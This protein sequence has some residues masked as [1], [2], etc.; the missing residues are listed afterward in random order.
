MT[1]LELGDM[2]GLIARGYGDLKAAC[3]LVLE[4]VDRG[5]ARTW[6]RTLAP[7]VTPARP[8]PD[9]E[10][11]HVAFTCE[12]LRQLG[13]DEQALE[14]FSR[15]FWEGMGEPHR[16]RHLLGDRD[17]SAPET[18]RWGGP[19]AHVLLLLFA[20]DPDLVELLCDR[21][22][23]AYVGLRELQRLDTYPFDPPREHFGFSDGIAQPIVEGLSRTGSPGNTIAPGEFI[24][25]YRNQYGKLPLS[26]VVAAD[27]DP[28][29]ILRRV[30]TEDGSEAGDLGRNGS[31][32]VFRQR[33]QD[34]R[35]FWRFVDKAARL[36]DGTSDREGRVR[37]AAKMVG[38]WPSGAP[39]TLCPDR[40]DTSQ[41]RRDDFGYL[42]RDAHGHFCPMGA[43]IRRTNPRD[44]LEGS[45]EESLMISNRHR[46]LRRGRPYG[47]PIS[48]TLDVDEILRAEE[49]EGEVGLHFICLNADIARQFE[50]VQHT[51]MNN[52]KFAGLYTDADP[53]MGHQE[54]SQGTFTLQGAPVRMRVN[55]MERFVEVRGGG[56][57]FL[58]SLRALQYLA[59]GVRTG[60]E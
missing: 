26:P 23:G 32:L 1:Q 7:H 22:R 60:S 13:V 59:T 14:T 57:F 31:Y 2:Q 38:R 29:R 39:L 24:L 37:M 20:R 44:S 17:G 54:Q 25:G 19:T 56:Y 47:A 3:Y 21:V 55:G 43:H 42:A 10:A 35:A 16:A 15:E 27:R 49:R 11:L 50:F 41:S 52:A 58:P 45:P 34:V 53:L 36:S 33:S 51:W 4:I 5:A 28:G 12:G 46:L 40:D 6:L 8:K 18:W 30:R 48:L 9:A